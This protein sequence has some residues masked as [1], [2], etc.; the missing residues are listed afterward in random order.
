MTYISSKCS[1][2]ACR[3]RRSYCVIYFCQNLIVQQNEIHLIQSLLVSLFSFW[4]PLHSQLK[5]MWGNLAVGSGDRWREV[6]VPSLQPGQVGVVSVA[7][8]APAL[9]GSYTSHWRL[10]HGGEQ[11][12]P[13]VWCSIVVDPLAPAA[14]MA[15]GVLVSPC[16]TPQVRYP[17]SPSFHPPSLPPSLPSSLPFPVVLSTMYVWVYSSYNRVV[18]TGEEPCVHWEAW[19]VLWRLQRAASH[20]GGPGRGG[21]LH[22]L[23]RPS[24]RTGAR[25]VC[26]S[27][28]SSV[29]SAIAPVLKPL[30]LCFLPF[31]ICC[32]SSCW[33]S[34]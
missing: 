10:A 23:R 32:P 28:H 3:D 16:V 31:R 30:S 34:T 11:F 19:E 29:L 12:G 9:E 14:M 2:L 1:W 13:R 22:P 7:L 6:S 8:C 4:L 33:T 17:S 25:C 27:S 24:H 5:F 20:V 18:F 26:F 15:D 21:V